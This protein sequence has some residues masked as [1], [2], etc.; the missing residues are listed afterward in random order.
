MTK[1]EPKSKSDAVL[2]VLSFLVMNQDKTLICLHK[3]DDKAF[4][5][6]VRLTNNAPKIGINNLQGA[7]FSGASGMTFIGGVFNGNTNNT[8]TTSSNECAWSINI[9]ST[10]D[11]I[12]TE[13]TDN[14]L[15]LVEDLSLLL[16]EWYGEV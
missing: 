1:Y 4:I 10:G 5:R 12:K 14:P 8:P 9:E 15:K 16:A 7:N 11:Y 3:G 2:A 6:L 13:P